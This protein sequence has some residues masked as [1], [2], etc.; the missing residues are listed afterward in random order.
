M[1]KILL[2][3]GLLLLACLGTDMFLTCWQCG[4]YQLRP[5]G[6]AT[7]ATVSL[8]IPLLAYFRSRRKGKHDR[9]EVIALLVFNPLMFAFMAWTQQVLPHDWSLSELAGRRTIVLTG[10]GSNAR[11]VQAIQAISFP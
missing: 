4:W 6:C 8:L 9:T 1:N 2:L 7:F 5:N 3:N 11:L 10:S